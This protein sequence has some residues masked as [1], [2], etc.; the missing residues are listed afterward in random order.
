MRPVGLRLTS[1]MPVPHGLQAIW[2]GSG[3]GCMEAQQLL[4]VRRTDSR[5]PQQVARG[6]NQQ[7]TWF[8]VLGRKAFKTEAISGDANRCPC[9]VGGS[10]IDDRV[11][12]EQRLIGPDADRVDQVKQS[13]RIRL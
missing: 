2:Y 10:P 11:T 6:V 12:H 13:G 3:L 7:V 4:I 9:G 1:A 5:Q 8:E